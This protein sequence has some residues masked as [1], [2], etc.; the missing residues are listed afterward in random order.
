MYY[1]MINEEVSGPHEM[2][3]IASMLQDGTILPFTL[4]VEEGHQNWM[5]LDKLV[6]IRI[7]KASYP[8][9]GGDLPPEKEHHDEHHHG[10]SGIKKCPFC[11]TRKIK[12][13]SK[14]LNYST[15]MH[16]FSPKVCKTC[17]AIWTP[18]VPKASAMQVFFIGIG[19]IGAASVFLAPEIAYVVGAKTSRMVA[20]GPLL[21]IGWILSCI[22]CIGGGVAVAKSLRYLRSENARAF[23]VLR[24]PH[25][26]SH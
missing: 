21:I 19:C 12:S 8:V 5:A 14:E 15:S 18:K 24:H 26:V 16:L 25:L 20:P 17:H 6:D 7:E 1:V 23:K 11:G 4:A 22:I 9:S 13:V 10:P 3:K 2:D